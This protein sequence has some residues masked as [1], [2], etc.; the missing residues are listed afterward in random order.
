MRWL[1]VAALLL[2]AL[3]EQNVLTRDGRRYTGRVTVTGP[4]VTIE[5]DSGKV[6][7]PADKVAC[8]FTDPHDAVK[9][10]DGYVEAAKKIYDEARV[11]PM[12]DP[13]RNPQLV[14][15]LDVLQR[16]R[17][18]YDGLSRYYEGGSWNIL[19]E[20]LR[21]A[22][23]LMRLVRDQRSEERRVGKECRL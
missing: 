3:N 12:R 19:S 11:L 17:D 16:A 1:L 10:A 21:T 15:A 20:N 9:R 8:V 2:F 23:Q 5:T 18:I 6:E 22:L 13:R 14:S 4:I 7:V